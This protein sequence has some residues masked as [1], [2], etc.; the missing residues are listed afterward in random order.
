[1]YTTVGLDQSDLCF[2]LRQIKSYDSLN[3][4]I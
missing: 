3:L 2:H 1:M 4:V